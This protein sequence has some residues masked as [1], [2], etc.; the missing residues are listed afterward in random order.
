[1]DIDAIDSTCLTENIQEPFF[2]IIA[3]ID[4]A[5]CYTTIDYMVKACEIESGSSCHSLLLYF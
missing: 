1:M 4:I 5:S 2:I 3:L